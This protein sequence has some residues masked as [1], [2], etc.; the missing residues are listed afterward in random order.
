MPIIEYQAGA[1]QVGANLGTGD[2]NVSL[3]IPI[4]AFNPS[5]EESEIPTHEL[6]DDASHALDVQNLAVSE[7]A[8]S[9]HHEN[10]P[11]E[12]RTPSR[13]LGIIEATPTVPSSSDFM[14]FR[15]DSESSGQSSQPITPGPGRQTDWLDSVLQARDRLDYTMLDFL[16]HMRFHMN[17]DVTSGWRSTEDIRDRDLLESTRDMQGLDWGSMGITRSMARSSRNSEYAHRRTDR[18][19]ERASRYLSRVDHANFYQFKRTHVKHRPKMMHWQLRHMLAATDRNNIFYASRD[20]VV[21]TSLACPDMN[22]AVMDL[23]C[24]AMHSTRTSAN[25][26]ITTIASTPEPIFPEY[27]SDSF[28]IAGGYGGEYALLDLHSQA[29]PQELTEGFV[30]YS[31]DGLTTHIHTT[32]NR[33][34]NTPDI[35]FCSND[36]NLHVL[37]ASTNT[38]L[39]RFP[40]SFE[41]N[42]AATSPDGR[43]RV[44]VGDS[45]QTLITSADTGEILHSFVDHTDHAFS[46]AWSPDGRHVATGAQDGL[47]MIYDSRYWDRPL[48]ILPCEL[49]CARSLQFTTLSSH[50]DGNGSS[51]SSSALVVAESDDY[52]SIWDAGGSSE[53]SANG[54]AFS[55]KQTIDFF[56][57]V[58]GVVALDAGKELVV[59]DGDRECGGLMVFERLRYPALDDGDGDG[60]CYGGL[61]RGGIRGEQRT[62]GAG[63]GG[64]MKEKE[65][66]EVEERYT[67]RDV[68][69]AKDKRKAR[70]SRWDKQE[71]LAP[72]L[73]PLRWEVGLEEI[74]I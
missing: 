39:N 25:V 12:P 62:G 66:E 63:G 48:E 7:P 14:H 1:S 67:D 33:R 17:S 44:L 9:L 43:L 41:L 26:R 55:R 56:G 34:T 23:G 64:R 8:Q 27:Q 11:F 47:V 19:E 16:D 40:Y 65:G 71:D 38:W 3:A 37:D 70:K 68:E 21:R 73:P 52:V 2:T 53:S 61:G 10:A 32:P 72:D 5:T 42:C 46:C 31:M 6:L 13:N 36:S 58:T 74:L 22:E 59:A 69:R 24:D 15:S 28:L 20:K 29:T 54:G 35:A 30:S 50:G 51:G 49:G 4:D 18:V 45:K 60:D 57:A